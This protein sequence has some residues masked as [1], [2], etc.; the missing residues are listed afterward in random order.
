[1]VDLRNDFEDEMY[2]GWRATENDVS[3][4]LAFRYRLFLNVYSS[5]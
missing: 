4:P 1:M 5:P 3:F 2:C